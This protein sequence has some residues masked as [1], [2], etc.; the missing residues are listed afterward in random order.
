[1]DKLDAV[2]FDVPSGGIQAILTAQLSR[3]GKLKRVGHA[4]IFVDKA[5]SVSVSALNSMTFDEL[6][7]FNSLMQ[8]FECELSRLVA[9]HSPVG[10]VGGLSPSATMRLA[11]E[12]LV[13]HHLDEVEVHPCDVN[14]DDVRARQCL[15]EVQSLHQALKA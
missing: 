6:G 12:K 5:P 2:V 8:R 10:C 3:G 1:M 9:A 7:R 4:Y 14:D 13:R 15:M 11:A